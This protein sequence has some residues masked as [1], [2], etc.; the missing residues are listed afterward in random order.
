MKLN[1]LYIKAMG[2]NGFFRVEDFDSLSVA[3]ESM[4][5]DMAELKRFEK[6]IKALEELSNGMK[7]RNSPI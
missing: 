4:V 6:R 2:E 5:Y 7:L 3:V 1:N